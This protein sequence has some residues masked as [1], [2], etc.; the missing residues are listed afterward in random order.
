MNM[1]MNKISVKGKLDELFRD[2]IKSEISEVFLIKEND[3]FFLQIIAEGETLLDFSKL[4]DFYH[5]SRSVIFPSN[6]SIDEAFDIFMNMNYLELLE[7][8]ALSFTGNEIEIVHAIFEKEALERM[9]LHR[10]N[11]LDLEIFHSENSSKNQNWFL[12]LDRKKVN[13]EPLLVSFECKASLLDFLKYDFLALELL[14]AGWQNKIDDF[15][16]D[17]GDSF[18]EKVDLY[19][20]VWD[21]MENAGVLKDYLNTIELAFHYDEIPLFVNKEKDFKIDFIGR[22]EELMLGE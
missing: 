4:V 7:D 5:C 14:D 16:D 12:V 19:A 10:T 6:L 1:E 17:F 8:L 9:E 11:Q 18:F 13:Q 22:K 21:T 2:W 20:K 15:E 3:Q